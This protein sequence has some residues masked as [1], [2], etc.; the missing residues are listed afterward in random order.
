M[1]CAVFYFQESYGAYV[2]R[3]VGFHDASDDD[4]DIG[5]EGKLRRRDTPHHLK[6]KRILSTQDSAEETVRAILAAKG[7]PIKRPSMESQTQVS[8][9]SCNN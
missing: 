6:N 9:L 5:P 3:H 2:E 1:C 4:Q 8:Y 7:G